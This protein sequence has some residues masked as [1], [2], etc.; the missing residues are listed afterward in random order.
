MTRCDSTIGKLRNCTSGTTAWLSWS[1]LSTSLGLLQYLSGGGI[2]GMVSNGI[3]SGSLLL[4]FSWPSSLAW[5]RALKEHCRS[6]RRFIRRNYLDTTG[7]ASDCRLRW[8]LWFNCGCFKSTV[9]LELLFKPNSVDL[10]STHTILKCSVLA[11][12]KLFCEFLSEAWA[13][14]CLFSPRNR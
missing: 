9:K 14:T 10:Q 4:F 3:P 6:T 13:F 11:G 8:E 2:D 12:R 7:F 1:R 5:C